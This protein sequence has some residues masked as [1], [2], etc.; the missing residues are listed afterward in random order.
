MVQ[1]TLNPL[2]GKLDIYAAGNS[3][4]GPGSSTVGNIPLFNNTSG[5]LLSDSGKAFT[6]DG[7]LSANSDALVPTEKAVK[8]YVDGV[9]T[10]LNFKAACYAATTGALTATYANGAAGVG[11]TLTNSGA[12]AAFSTDGQSPPINSRILVKN[13]AS[14][15]ENGIYTLTTVGTGAVAWVLTRAIDFDQ[16]VEIVP[17]STTQILNGTTLAGSGWVEASASPVVGTDP[18]TFIEYIYPPSTFLQVLNNLSDLNNTTT[19]RSNLGVA[20]GTNVQAFNANLQSI[21]ALGTAAD[22]MLYTTGI[23]TWAESAITSFGRTLVAS[24]DAAAARTSLALG[25]I[26]T[27]AA[28][29]VSISGG[30]ID[31]TTVGA[32]TPSTGAFTTL[33]ASGKLTASAGQVVSSTVPGAYPYTVLAS[34]YLILVDTASARTINLPNAPTTNTVYVIKDNV[35]SAGTNAITLTTLGGSVTIDGATSQTLASNWI[36]YTVVFNGTSY[37]II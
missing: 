37:R 12:L 13:Q 34:D 19:A 25:T 26:S 16:T 17:G 20:I 35:G 23:A 36:S 1:F 33:S 31:G 14:T 18:I 32:S 3:V 2:T 30:S 4:I 29:A 10:G 24:A 7:T 22:K 15:L 8:T 21:S 28:S 5:T 27:Q 11:A 6:T 9:A